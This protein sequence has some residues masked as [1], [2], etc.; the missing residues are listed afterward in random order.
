MSHSIKACSSCHTRKIR[1]DMDRVGVPCTKCKQDGFDCSV[2]DRKPR[3]SKMP[4]QHENSNANINIMGIRPTPPEAVPEHHMLYKFPFYSLFRNMTLEDKPPAAK[5]GHAA[6]VFP[7]PLG[8][9]F[10]SQPGT[11]RGLTPYDTYYLLQKGALQLPS[12][13]HMDAMVANYFRLFHASFPLVDR[14]DFLTRYRKT[15]S[16]GILAGQGPSLLL[17]QAILFT[18][19]PASSD[20]DIESMG[21]YSRRHARSVF[22]DRCRCLYNLSY[23][24][25]DIA[26]IQALLLM[27]QYF[28]SMD[29][30]KHTWLWAHQAI[31]LAQ[32]IGLHRDPGEAAPQRRLWIRIWWVCVIRDRLIALGT[33]RPLHINSLDCTT[34]LPTPEDLAEAGDSADDTA[35]KSLFI[36]FAKLCHYMEGVLS[37]PMASQESL[38][39]QIKLCEGVLERWHDHLKPIA[40]SSGQTPENQQGNVV[41]LFATILQLLFNTV[42]IVLRQSGS[43][44]DEF[45]EG[46]RKPPSPAV[47]IVA[48]ESTRL[49]INLMDLDMIQA[50]PTF[51][52]TTALP[53]IAFYLHSLQMPNDAAETIVSK[54]G[55]RVCLQLFEKLGDIHWHAGF[56]RSFFQMIATRTV[57]ESHKR[58]GADTHDPNPRRR[59]QWHDTSQGPAPEN[60]N[61]LSPNPLDMPTPWKTPDTTT[62]HDTPPALSEPGSSSTASPP[63]Q[64]FMSMIPPELDSLLPPS[65]DFSLDD[66]MNVDDG[67]FD[68][69]LDDHSKTQTVPPS[70]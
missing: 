5:K 58:P 44:L 36:E 17:L 56:Y 24:I 60:A 13:P 37:L 9:S 63:A 65:F 25:E 59:R 11:E 30:Q 29:G 38:P 42:M 33:R 27:S 2:H 69:W 53:V 68:G 49:F 70:A 51:C 18:A 34:N 20:L 19:V 64:R 22:Y 28:P 52:V 8:E 46:E 32:G 54:K 62:A 6:S 1:C 67:V 57:V 40:R 16:K 35:V 12:R 61:I 14:E 4:Q 21:F 41:T 23:E 10:A 66:F 31:T 47:R 3:Q 39:Q 50:C 7:M 26:N 45:P 15:D 43:R 55:F 48:E